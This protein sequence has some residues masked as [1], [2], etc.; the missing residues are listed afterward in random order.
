MMVLFCGVTNCPMTSLFLVFELFGFHSLVLFL[1]ADAVGYMLS[2]Y[3]GLYNE[4][5]IMY[6]K[7][8]VSF[9]NNNANEKAD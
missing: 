5:K 4:Q 7:Y 6:S 8:E 2:G 9:I 3:Y 1:I